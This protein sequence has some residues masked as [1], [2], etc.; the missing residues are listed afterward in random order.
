[1]N[2][3]YFVVVVIIIVV[4]FRDK[5]VVRKIGST[6]IYTANIIFHG[7]YNNNNNNNKINSNKTTKLLITITIINRGKFLGYFPSKE[8]AQKAFATAYDVV[9][10]AI[11]IIFIIVVVFIF[12]VNITCCY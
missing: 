9:F 5:H 11:I 12:N 7:R 8:S 6:S 3:N 10:V 4:V 2:F 1:M